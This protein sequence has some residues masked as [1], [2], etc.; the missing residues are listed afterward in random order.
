MRQVAVDHDVF[1][2]EP[3]LFV[4]L[5]Q[6]SL[7]RALAGVDPAAREADLAGVVAQVA[8]WVAQQR[9]RGEGCPAVPEIV[10]GSGAL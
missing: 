6:R 4:G 7:H 3:D 8:R 2:H 10:F 9:L 5:A 1:G